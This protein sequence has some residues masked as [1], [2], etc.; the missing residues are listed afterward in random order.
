[1]TSE[2]A[3]EFIQR[4]PQGV[5]AKA[6]VSYARET[7]TINLN[8]DGWKMFTDKLSRPAL[9]ASDYLFFEGVI[10][11]KIGKNSGSCP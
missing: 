7:M 10:S 6:R 8:S 11:W 4:L 5:E 1:M 3:N 9:F 2:Q